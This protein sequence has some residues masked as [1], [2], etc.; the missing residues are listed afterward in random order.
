MITAAL[1]APFASTIS[2]EFFFLVSQL[3]R[4][5]LSNDTDIYSFLR[6][7][8]GDELE[9]IQ[10]CFVMKKS[11]YLLST[12]KT[13]ES[14]EVGDDDCSDNDEPKWMGVRNK[15]DTE[16]IK[17]DMW[18]HDVGWYVVTLDGKEKSFSLLSSE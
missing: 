3:F 17:E 11:E 5:S 6:F 4:S 16:A 9:A 12:Q 15:L 10:D 2:C 18:S 8:D 7:D 13:V 14:Y 1:T